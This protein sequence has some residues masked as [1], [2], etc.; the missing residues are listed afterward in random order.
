METAFP[1]VRKGRISCECVMA[2][3][4]P[5][6]RAGNGSPSEITAMNIEGRGQDKQR[7]FNFAKHWRARWI[8]E[9][10]LGRTR[11]ILGKGGDS[12]GR[13]QRLSA[14]GAIRGWG[15]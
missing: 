4:G 1:S 7:T 3:R 12:L 11:G 14:G 5:R 10:P 6:I 15:E 8:K 13:Q 2:G 9:R